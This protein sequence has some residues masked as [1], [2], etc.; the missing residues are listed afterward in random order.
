[1]TTQ[2]KDETEL[3]YRDFLEILA[4]RINLANIANYD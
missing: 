1:M 3:R 2:T 4:T